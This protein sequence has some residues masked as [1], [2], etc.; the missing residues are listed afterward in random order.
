M[1]QT[2]PPATDELPPEPNSGNPEPF[3]GMMDTFLAALAPFRSGM[4]ALATNCYNNAMD[5]YDS[6]VS[7]AASL[8]GVVA[9]GAAT[10]WISGSTYAYGVVVWSPID[11]LSYRR[12]VA[13]AG[14]TDPSLDATNWATL[15]GLVDS[16]T[17]S[18][19]IGTGE[20][21]FTVSTGKGFLGGMYL[22]IADTAAPSTNS[23]YGQ[24]T[25]YSGATLVMNIL[26][27]RGSGTKTA[28]TISQSA[29][30]INSIAKNLTINGS[31]QISQVNGGSVVVSATGT[32]PIDNVLFSA[33]VA[34]KISH[35]QISTS[36][37]A[38]DASHA[39]LT[40]VQA[41]YSPAAG[42][43]FINQW[44][45]EGLN[46]AHLK[47]G[48]VN[49]KAVSL[50]FEAIAAVAGTYSGSIINAANN[51][52]YPFSFT[53]AAATT[54]LVKIENIPGYTAG[55]WP[56]TAALSL[57]VS[58]DMGCGS[59]YKTTGDAWASGTYYGVTGA[60]A[61]VSQA[62]SSILVITDV[63]LNEGSQCKLFE[64]K[65]WAV[66][67]RDCQRYHPVI[68]GDSLTAIGPGMAYSSTTAMVSVTFP[69]STR[70]P[71]TGSTATNAAIFSCRLANASGFSACTSHALNRASVNGCDIDMIGMSGLAGATTCQFNQT[72]KIIFVG[73]EL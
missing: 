59:N 17:T 31:C 22:I 69:V 16:S 20:K 25:S 52:S 6:A 61:L 66:E 14:T 41:S 55:T 9:A 32:Y 60:S 45:H 44:R 4:I 51:L 11:F 56:T 53:L 19:S 58:F 18:N 30:T 21:T 73:P 7:A 27:V 5:A 70:V 42:D 35:Q 37:Y 62:T 10:E 23:M 49:A 24:V 71:V 67:L 39:L 63:Q 50:Q 2:P 38:L 40:A 28:W 72:S 8:A 48:T 46:T 29:G 36:S 26:S 65:L 34:S 33:S 57:S 47:W 1:A 3:A 43:F 13:G 15:N 64:R 54:T 68:S 12:K